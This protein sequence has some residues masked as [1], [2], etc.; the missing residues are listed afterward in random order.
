METGAWC[1]NGAGSRKNSREGESVLRK[2]SR[3]GAIRFGWERVA[4]IWV[5]GD[6]WKGTT[7]HRTPVGKGI[8]GKGVDSNSLKFGMKKGGTHLN[9]ADEIK[10]D[11]RSFPL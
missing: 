2:A 7:D 6:G 10:M 4:G 1:R 11:P 3:K 5:L 9:T 8:E